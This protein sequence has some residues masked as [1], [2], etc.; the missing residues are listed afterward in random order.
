M[1]AGEEQPGKRGAQWWNCG[2][3]LPAHQATSCRAD[4]I[5]AR[6]KGPIELSSQKIN[7]LKTS[8]RAAFSVLPMPRVEKVGRRQ[9]SSLHCTVSF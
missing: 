2:G 3:V 9:M 4:K 1:R 7:R 6:L 5:R 8:Q